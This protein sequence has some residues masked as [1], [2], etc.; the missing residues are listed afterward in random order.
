MVSFRDIVKASEKQQKI[1]DS[2][3]QIDFSFC[4][5]ILNNKVV[6]YQQTET[7]DLGAPYK[8][9]ENFITSAMCCPRPT[10]HNCIWDPQRVM[11]LHKQFLHTSSEACL[12][13]V[14]QRENKLLEISNL[15]SIKSV[16]KPCIPLVR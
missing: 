5:E 11:L 10:C 6:L 13:Y 15:W 4:M 9:Y 12:V 1:E 3:D 7:I 8:R 2:T 14:L 16:W